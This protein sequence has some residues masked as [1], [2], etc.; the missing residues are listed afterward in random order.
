MNITANMDYFPNI[1]P[2]EK[3]R[4]N[5]V[6]NMTSTGELLAEAELYVSIKNN[7][8]NKTSG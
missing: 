3:G 7:V 2:F 6:F 8:K 4:A 1:L 5:L